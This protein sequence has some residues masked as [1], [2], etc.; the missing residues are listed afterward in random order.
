MMLSIPDVLNAEQLQQCRTALAGGNWQD[1]RLTAGH[2]A[3]SVKANQQLAQDDPLTQQLGDFILAC[4]AQHPRFMAGALPLKVVPPR[5]NRYA[6]GGTYGD[7][8][9]NAVFSV[10]GTPHRIRADLSATLFFSEPDEYDGGELVVQDQRIKL[11]AGHLVLYSSGS[12]HRVEPVTRGVRLA[13]FFWVQ[14]LV[15][16]DE[17]RSVL[18]E[19]DDSIQ[20]L[21]QQVPNSPELIRLT[22]I[23]H[24][25]LRQ[26]TQ[27]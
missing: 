23:Y 1:G 4:L 2:Q 10:P 26:W 13:S 6:E 8:I 18:L 11:P 24:N 27:T 5:F 7:H 9:D 20:A 21:R 19:L 17:Q 16:Q 3:V 12:L 15:R 25:L 14:S 22:G